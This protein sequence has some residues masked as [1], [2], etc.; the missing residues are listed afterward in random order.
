MQRMANFGTFTQVKGSA[1]GWN[2]VD[3][4]FENQ[5][6]NFFAITFKVMRILTEHIESK[7]N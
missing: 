1:M 2:L 6:R 4:I 7:D 3:L 5:G